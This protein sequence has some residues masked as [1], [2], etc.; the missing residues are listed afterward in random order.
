MENDILT[1]DK[2][3]LPVSS[4]EKDFDVIEKI[5]INTRK[6]LAQI[7]S[8]YK[9]DEEIRALFEKIIERKMEQSTTILPPFQTDFGKNIVLGKDV[10]INTG[11]TFM[12]RGGI[13]IGNGAFIGPDVKLI[14]ISHD[15]NPQKRYITYC[16][17]VK[18]REL[19]LS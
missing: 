13:E 11:C 2:N 6:I 19:P 3:G 14:T 5:Q 10:F 17:P 9:S 1:R 8:G 18:I 4:K 16:K 12:D 7:N 15:M